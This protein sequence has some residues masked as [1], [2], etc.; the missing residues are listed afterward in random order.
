MCPKMQ[1]LEAQNKK[2]HLQS[3]VSGY[4]YFPTEMS[5]S[6]IF[7]TLLWSWNLLYAPA[8][9]QKPAPP[10]STAGT[11]KGAREGLGADGSETKKGPEKINKSV[12]RFD[13]LILCAAL[14][15]GLVL[16]VHK[17]N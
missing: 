16:S 4:C 15:K 1:F 10:H 17:L 5:S 14:N 11:A 7:C 2:P 6:S 3:N 13:H 9:C 8:S 12:S